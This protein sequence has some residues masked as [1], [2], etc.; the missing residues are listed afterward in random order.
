MN[1][2]LVELM[3]IDGTELA[4]PQLVKSIK[5]KKDCFELTR[6]NNTQLI[7]PKTAIK[8]IQLGRIKNA[9]KPNKKNKRKIR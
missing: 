7:V 9:P 8:V 6:E 2:K 3:F 4:F 1:L 5:E